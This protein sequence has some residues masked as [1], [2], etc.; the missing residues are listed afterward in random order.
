[1]LLAVRLKHGLGKEQRYAAD[2]KR[3]LPLGKKLVDHA[4]AGIYLGPAYPT[5]G[6]L[7]YFLKKRVI[8]ACVHVAF[9]ETSFPGV[10]ET[11][12]IDDQEASDVSPQE[13]VLENVQHPLVLDPPSAPILSPSAPPTVPLPFVLQSPPPLPVVLSAEAHFGWWP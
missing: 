5:P 12:V 6:H 7:V 2:K 13:V 11:P 10:A 3:D 9:D 8:M 1:M 4:A